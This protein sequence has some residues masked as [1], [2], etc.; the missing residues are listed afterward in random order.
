MIPGLSRL[1]S[2]A[3]VKSAILSFGRSLPL[4]PDEQ[5]SL[6]SVGMSEKCHFRT[7]ASQQLLALFDHLVR[8]EED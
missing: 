7:H 6:P 1:M 4:H 2:V 3:G 8:S 5:T